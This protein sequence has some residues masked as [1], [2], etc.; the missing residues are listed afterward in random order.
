MTSNYLQRTSKRQGFIYKSPNNIYMISQVSQQYLHE[1]YKPITWIDHQRAQNFSFFEKVSLFSR[2]ELFHS[3]LL[4][5]ESLFLTYTIFLL[6]YLRIW[7]FLLCKQNTW[8][9]FECFSCEIKTLGESLSVLLCKQ[10]TCKFE[11]SLN[12]TTCVK[13]SWALGKSTPTCNC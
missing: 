9:E 13:V 12:K 5:L 1:I 4:F 7:V 6:L 10:N 11:W 2:V 8:W 3:Y